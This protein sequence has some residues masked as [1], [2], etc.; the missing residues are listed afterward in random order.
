M[1]CCSLLVYQ[2]HPSSI[3]IDHLHEEEALADMMKRTPVGRKEQFNS[4]QWAES[5]KEFWGMVKKN[6]Q[7]KHKAFINIGCGYDSNFIVSVRGKV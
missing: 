4:E 5:K 6:T 7:G 2:L 1:N 3:D